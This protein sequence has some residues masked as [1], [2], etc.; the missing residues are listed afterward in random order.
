[1]PEQPFTV[2]MLRDRLL[3]FDQDAEIDLAITWNEGTAV[4]TV[5]AP[6]TVV[7]K[8]PMHNALN[9]MAGT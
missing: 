5:K 6:L 9:F 4:R 8:N 1:M 7:A 2:G 3:L